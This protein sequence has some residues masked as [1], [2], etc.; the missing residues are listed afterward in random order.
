MDLWQKWKKTE[1]ERLACYVHKHETVRVFSAPQIDADLRRGHRLDA[2]RRVY[3]HLAGQ[4]IRYDTARIDFVTHRRS[5][6]E[7]RQ[8]GEVAA[9]GG[10]CLELALLFAG[11]CEQAKLLPLLVLLEQHVLVAVRLDEDA[12]LRTATGRPGPHDR[13]LLSGGLLPPAADVHVHAAKLAE[14]EAQGR[15]V[16]I[17]CTGMASWSGRLTFD[18]AARTGLTQL[19]DTVMGAL[20]QV[21]DVAFFHLQDTPYKSYQLPPRPAHA[22]DADEVV[23]GD[24]AVEAITELAARLEPAPAVPLR[25]NATGLQ[26]MLAT[27]PR[28]SEL[29]VLVAG[30]VQVLGA[31]RFARSWMPHALTSRRL[32]AAL[33]ETF[34]GRLPAPGSGDT[35]YLAHVFLHRPVTQTDWQTELVRYVVAVARGAGLDLRDIMLRDWAISVIG[36]V[37]TNEVLEEAERRRKS[38]RWRLRISLHGSPTGRWPEA[39]SAWLFDGDRQIPA[40]AEQCEPNQTSVEDAIGAVLEWAED[41]A[42]E[43]GDR[44]TQVEI[45]VP[46]SL[47][48]QW[49]PEETKVGSRIGLHHDVV[50]RWSERLGP[51]R[52]LRRLLSEAP[53]R[54]QFIDQHGAEGGLDW[55]ESDQSRDV[56]AVREQLENGTFQG[57][58][59]LRFPP[60]QREELLEMLLLF[61]PVLL[62]PDA[63]AC[64]WDGIDQELRDSWESLPS[65]LADAYRTSWRRHGETPTLAVVRAVWDDQDWLT[66]CRNYLKAQASLRRKGA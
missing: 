20:T 3:E 62:W 26:S 16:L 48:A 31:A 25:W 39:V 33:I 57:A 58:I 5:E 6:Q 28:T 40:E 47:L 60:E 18:E 2:V 52:H 55:L 51:P 24:A 37:R 41:I 9:E 59:G 45:A 54:W 11:L 50:V 4:G 8:P 43:A 44:L 66:F 14:W 15:C 10:N 46:T 7:V 63:D 32:R 34:R 61:S 21:V 35:D 53:R 19:T 12:D 65:A 42:I 56:E 22:T 36:T 29:G 23:L 17:E 30:L 38:A 27:V 49:R 13:E 1:P 64:P